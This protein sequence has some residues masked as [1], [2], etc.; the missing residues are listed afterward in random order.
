[1]RTGDADLDGVDPRVA[2]VLCAALAV[3]AAARPEPGATV[4]GLRRAAELGGGSTT[5]VA[6]AATAALGADAPGGTRVMPVAAPE[7]VQAS[8]PT[9]TDPAGLRADDSGHGPYADEPYADE[10]YADQT[11]VDEADLP[12]P[13]RRVGT[14]LALAAVLVAAGAAWPGIA[15]L[16]AVVLAIMVRGVGLDVDALHARRMRRGT[17]GGDTARAVVSWPWYLLRALLGVLPAALVAASAV[18]VVGGVGWWLVDTG[19]VAVAEPPPGEVAGDLAGNAAWVVHALLAVA[20]LVGLLLVWFGPMSRATRRGARWTLAAVAP[21]RAGAATA[22]LL[23]LAAAAVLVA[24]VV[25]GH[26]V[27]WWP[28]PGS[29]DLR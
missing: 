12:G 5:V 1:V 2:E 21:G 22:V 23:A 18:V 19:R 3:D 13:R 11:E 10:P 7:P 24:L 14:V 4:A 29:P 15:L 17:R 16:V 9:G 26:P 8:G 25:L 6:G 27:A 28:L 20:L